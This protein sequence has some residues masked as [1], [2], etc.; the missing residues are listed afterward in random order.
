MVLHDNKRLRSK[1]KE[2][3]ECITRLIWK[4]FSR[5]IILSSSLCHRQ[6]IVVQEKTSIKLRKSLEND[7]LY[8]NSEVANQGHGKFADDDWTTV[9]TMVSSRIDEQ[10]G[11]H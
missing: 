5:R 8:T 3:I 11:P 9:C 4:S 6:N 10:N 1:V 7:D 2:F